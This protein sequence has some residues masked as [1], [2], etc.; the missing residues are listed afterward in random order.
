M[1]TADDPTASEP[2]NRPTAYAVAVFVLAALAQLPTFNRSIVPMDEG[3]LAAVA[4]GLGDG[5]ALYRD[6]HS[7]IFPGIY[8]LS[9]LLFDLFGN[10]LVVA[11]WAQVITNA[12]V[13]LCLWLAGLRVMPRTW[14]VLAPVLYLTVAVMSFPVLSMFNYSSL[15]LAL[16]MLSLLL[17]MRVLESGDRTSALALGATL[18][19]AVF[20]KQNFGALA[21]AAAAIGIFANRRS[22]VLAER[23]WLSFLLPIAGAGIAVTTGFV[24]YFLVTG[25][26]ADFLHSTVIQ[27]GGDQLESFNNPIPP[28]FGP[29]PLDDGKFVFLYSPP[30]LFNAMLRGETVFGLSATPGLASAA[31][32]FAYGLAL[33]T[34][35]TTPA[36]WLLGVGRTQGGTQRNTRLVVVFA[37]L[38][39][40][41]IFPSAIFSHL[42]FVLAPVLLA[43]ALCL[44]RL[45]AALCGG[46]AGAS[47]ALRGLTLAAGAIAVT[48]IAV[49]SA[50]IAGWFPEPLGIE[51]A[52][53]KVSEGQAE[54]Y[55][56][57]MA[58]VEGC[59]D[60]GE[61]IFVAPT[62]PVAY[63]L[64]TRPSVSRYD[65][66]IPGN[67]DGAAI[68]SAIETRGTR[69][70]V[71]NP[72]MYPEFPPFAA[73]FPE[74]DRYLKTRFEPRRRIRGG[75][76]VWL[77]LVPSAPERRVR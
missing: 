55:R 33:L 38:F 10:D 50:T 61:A 30:Y 58:F 3:H 32:R 34:L 69:C 6:L 22:S 68:V 16:C 15:A 23:P 11:R 73:M 66:T 12:S 26:F 43:F 4:M 19:L 9:T 71:Y 1:K 47:M 57:T 21:F 18:A 45:D 37:L 27:L 44:A 60:P 41:G 56:G 42:V 67:V 59:A 51:R 28:I 2:D 65:L 35:V 53:L 13:C 54:I 39:F 40:L 25:T 74:L 8:L 20:S 72:A 64:A 31:A 63:F 62:L 52:S 7:G 46:A 14:S 75:G 17:T 49:G 48:F 36:I 5:L 76:E 77:G 24:G 29:H 70:I